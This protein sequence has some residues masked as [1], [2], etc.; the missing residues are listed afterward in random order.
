[1][2]KCKVCRAKFTKRSMTHKACSPECSL[3]LVNQAKKKEKAKVE[4][5]DRVKTKKALESLKTRSDWMKDA[6]KVFNEF[7]RERDKAEP[8]I[9]CQRFHQGQY[10]AGHFVSVG[11]RPN[12]RFD[13]QNVHRQ[14]APCNNHLS[15]N[16]IHYRMNLIKKLG[17][18]AVVRLETDF[19]PKKYTI[20]DLKEI[21]KIYRNKVKMLKSEFH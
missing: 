2:T 6:Q 7:I 9:S 1:M 12:L 3:I 21:I 13:E 16:I 5:L 18:E 17:V 11:S 15:G 10:H 14:C 4:R 20:D 8:C 19:E